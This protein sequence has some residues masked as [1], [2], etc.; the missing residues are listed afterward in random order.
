[1]LSLDLYLFFVTL[2]LCKCRNGLKVV[3]IKHDS[4]WSERAEF[5]TLA[6]GSSSLNEIQNE[7]NAA[8]AISYCR[9]TKTIQCSAVQQSEWAMITNGYC[10][11]QVGR[12]HFS[13]NSTLRHWIF[14]P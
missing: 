8:K 12:I 10:L 1:M 7:T 9:S 14:K 6:V 13:K 4:R 11:H 2:T 3:Y 5:S